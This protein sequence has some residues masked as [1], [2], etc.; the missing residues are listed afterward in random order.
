MRLGPRACWP[1]MRRRSPLA[2]RRTP[3]G[4][5]PRILQCQPDGSHIW[6]SPPSTGPLKLG[7]ISGGHLERDVDLGEDL[8][9][10][11]AFPGERM[12][13]LVPFGNEGDEL[14]FWVRLGAARP[15]VMRASDCCAAATLRGRRPRRPHQRAPARGRSVRG[16][17]RWDACRALSP[18]RSARTTS[19]RDRSRTSKSSRRARQGCPGKPRRRSSATGRARRSG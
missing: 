18:G 1:T 16:R 3:G 15:I 17:A 10:R 13:G 8:F 6:L 14:V 4:V 19:A 2:R 7:T 12:S 9:G 11:L 5:L